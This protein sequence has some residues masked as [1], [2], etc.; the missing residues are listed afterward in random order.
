MNPNQFKYRL[1]LWE[2]IRMFLDRKNLVYMW[3][4]SPNANVCDVK[5]FI[6][7]D[8]FSIDSRIVQALERLGFYPGY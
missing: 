1:S 2:R 8:R 3:L 6:Y 7:I 4:P 5:I